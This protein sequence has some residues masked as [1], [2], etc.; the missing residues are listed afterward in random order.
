MAMKTFGALA[1]T[2]VILSGCVGTVDP[3]D[4]AVAS[5]PAAFIAEALAGDDLV[6]VDLA[7]TGALHDFEPSAR[8]L[9]QLRQS[10][11]LVLWDEQLESWAHRTEESLGS[12]APRVI[13][14]T[15]LPAGE[16][17]IGEDEDAHAESE[18]GADEDDGHG[19]GAWDPHTWNDPLAMLASVQ[20]LEG[21]LA[22]AY[23]ELANAIHAR[24][25]ALEAQLLALDSE[26]Q[27][28][29][30][31]CTRDTIVTNHEAHNYLARRYNF[32]VFALHGLEP[33]SQPSPATV[34][35][36]IRTIKE[37]DLPAIF[38][39]EGTDSR[40]LQAIQD[41][42]GVDIRVLITNEVRPD[43]GNYL[44]GQRHNLDQLRF[45]LGCT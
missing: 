44:D 4:I 19:H 1:V 41:E 30:E 14:I 39:E 32:T 43:T 34:D 27:T 22:V 8:D 9:N 45:A 16:H 40:A 28:G 2:A 37:L 15:R 18:E 13:E 17:Y 5:Y 6:V 7:P 36:A 21:Y 29:L 11:H 20:A 42:T 10:T 3:A 12:S 24:A 23:P 38:I 33:G 35:E 25:E 31:D 26:I